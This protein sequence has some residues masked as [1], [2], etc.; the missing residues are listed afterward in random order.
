MHMF[1]AGKTGPKHTGPI[2]IGPSRAW[3][4]INLFVVDMCRSLDV[5]EHRDAQTASR[6]AERIDPS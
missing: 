2:S 5:I 1:S 4:V 6:L 3:R